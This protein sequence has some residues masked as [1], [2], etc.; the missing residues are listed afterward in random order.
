MGP[1]VHTPE[2]IKRKESR[3]KRRLQPVATAAYD[4]EI[5]RWRRKAEADSRPISSWIRLR[6]LQAE[7]IEEEKA[8]AG[9][10]QP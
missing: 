6:V 9:A 10:S 7:A 1:K 5:E 8:S 4:E 2:D 3:E